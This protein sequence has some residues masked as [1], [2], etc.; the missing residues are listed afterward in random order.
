MQLGQ[1]YIYPT[2]TRRHTVL[3]KGGS[4]PFSTISKGKKTAALVMACN[5]IS[6]GRECAVVP[7]VLSYAL[8]NCAERAEQNVAQ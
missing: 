7:C 2:A 5:G 8:G 1:N 6:K 3:Q 4:K